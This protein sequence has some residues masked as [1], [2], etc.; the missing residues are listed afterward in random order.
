MEGALV[1]SSKLRNINKVRV[2]LH[3]VYNESCLN[4]NSFNRVF[5]GI[6]EAVNNA[7]LHGNKLNPE[8]KVFI[9]TNLNENRLHIEIEDQGE[10][11]SDTALTD[12]TA[13]ENIKYEHGRGIYILRQLADHLVFKDEGRKIFIQFTLP[14]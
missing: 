9:R 1:I 2:F 14:E 5:L 7:I 11:F 12:P 8:K 6:S 3:E 4:M 10:G 13:V